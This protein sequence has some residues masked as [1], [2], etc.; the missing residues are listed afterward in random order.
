M[1]KLLL[2]I[3]IT[4]SINSISYASHILGGEIRWECL[5]DGRFIFYADLY[6][7]CSSGAASFNFT[8]HQINITGNPLPTNSTNNIVNQITVKPDSNRWQNANNGDITPNCQK[9][10]VVSYS[11][12]NGS[13]GAVQWYPFTSD[14]IQ[15]KGTPPQSG[16]TLIFGGPNITCC[17]SPI[18]QNLQNPGSRSFGMRAKMFPIPNPNGTSPQFLSVDFCSDSSP[19]FAEKPA[20]LF[21]R[22][23]E[24]TISQNA[25]D[26]ELDSMV[27]SFDSPVDNNQMLLNYVS[28]YS[29]TNPLP[30]K[31][32]DSL[33]IPLSL[34]SLTGEMKMGLYSGSGAESFTVVVRVDAWRCGRIISSIWRDMPFLFFDCNLLPDGDKNSPPRILINGVPRDNYSVDAV[35][36]EK[37]IINF[38]SSDNDIDTTYSPP[39]QTV[40]LEPNG[41]LFA[42]DFTDQFNC[43]TSG[44]SPCATLN[45]PPVQ[46]TGQAFKLSQLSSVSTQFNW[47]TD[48]NHISVTSG[49][50]C[51][52]GTG[53]VGLG[54]GIF[55]FV[56]KTYDDHC[57]IPAINFPTIAIKVKAPFPISNPMVKGVSIGLDGLTTINWVPPIDS[58]NTFEE[59]DIQ[60]ATVGQ[61]SVPNASFLNIQQG[62]KNYKQ[63]RT[64]SYVQFLGNILNPIP[65]NKDYYLRMQTYSGCTGDIPSGWSEPAR[66]MEIVI[67]SGN[68]ETEANLTWNP[69][70]PANAAT[71]PNFVYESRTKY[72]IHQNNFKDNIDS[73]IEPLNWFEVGSTFNENYQVS[74]SVCNDKVAFRIEARDTV[75]TYKQGSCIN[76]PNPQY[77]TLYFSSFSMVDSILLNKATPTINHDPLNSISSNMF[78]ESYQW[79]DC[80]TNTAI[81]G[82]TDKIYIPAKPGSYKV[83]IGPTNCLTSSACFAI[84]TVLNDSVTQVDNQTLLGANVNQKFQWIDC[85]ADTLIPGATNREFIPSDTG[86]YSLVVSAYGY[87]DTSR[88]VPMIAIGILEN[89]FEKGLSIF[90]NPAN[91]VFKLKSDKQRIQSVRVTNIKGQLVQDFESL[92]VFELE[93]DLENAKGVFLLE[94]INENGHRS[95]QKLIKQ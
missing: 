49:G 29:F 75:V 25:K 39:F 52:N 33:N 94:I 34:N 14:P 9:P 81:S 41:F 8:N 1:K 88:C 68:N 19:E 92:R 16:W 4:L 10:G 55:N 63:E 35:A 78:A 2:F 42:N 69:T 70:K 87:K 48:C 32:F 12:N 60:G 45:P 47:Q 17:R 43:A 6:K 51:G 83:Q 7:D 20:N 89:Q 5:S 53:I 50:F 46:A 72:Y 15:L 61:G 84:T 38:Q 3:L 11:C 26:K 27:Y 31:A 71:N 90:P 40:S 30:N 59:Y 36:G 37:V 57:P 77:D 28:G 58:S 62:V 56:M 65:N 67:T 23:Y 80:N 91:G 54:E 85:R 74:S 21:C 66:V 95:F 13:Y 24:F 22:A 86:Y 79:I 82:A 93:I 64:F 76:M 73:L 44:V 18:N